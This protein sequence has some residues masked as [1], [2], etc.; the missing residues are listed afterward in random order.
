[1]W[2]LAF[3]EVKPHHLWDVA[4]VEGDLNKSPVTAGSE[5]LATVPIGVLQTN[6]HL[7]KKPNDR[8]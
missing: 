5:S 3:T 4:D 8:V 1:M 7:P 2:T 6:Q